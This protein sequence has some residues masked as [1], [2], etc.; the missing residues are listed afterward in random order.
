MMRMAGFRWRNARPR[1][2]ELA[3]LVFPVL[4]LATRT[5]DD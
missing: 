2:L 3:L 5:D 1:W 4:L